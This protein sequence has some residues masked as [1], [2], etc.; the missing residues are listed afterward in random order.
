MSMPRISLRVLTAAL[1]ALAL[2]PSTR[3]VQ[4]DER[5]RLQQS[6]DLEVP[7]Q[8]NTGLYTAYRTT[9]DP[10]ADDPPSYGQWTLPVDWPASAVHSIVLRTGKVLWFRGD[11]DVPTTYVWDPSSGQMTSQAL[12][13]IIWCG[14]NSVLEDGRVLMTGGA[15]FQGASSGP[16]HAWI[17]D[18]QTEQ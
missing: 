17:F 16:R 18:P 4:A 1:V 6:V 8:Q 10:L 5:Q 7:Q 9:V 13:G 3:L 12:T 15:L 11:E 14:G 2:C